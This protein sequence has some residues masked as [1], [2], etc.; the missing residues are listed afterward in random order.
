MNYPELFS[1]SFPIIGCVHLDALPGSPAYG[2]KMNSIIDKAISDADKLIEGGCDGLI[3]E[4]FGD[5]PFYPDR[6]PSITVSAM[7]VL[8]SQIAQ[9][10]ALPIGINVLRNDA[11]A[12]ISIAAA[13]K[14]SFVR[15][16]IHM[17]A[18]LT[19]QG[20]VQGKSFETL[21]LRKSLGSSALIFADINVKHASPL[22][23][24]DIEQCAK[25]LIYRG[26]ADA[27]IVS[28]SGTGS[29][30]SMEELKAVKAISS[31]PVLLGSGVNEDNLINYMPIAD[32]AIIGTAF[33]KDGIV[34]N[35]V[36]QSKVNQFM[37]QLHHSD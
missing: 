9:R 8:A 6:V 36:D 5:A 15:I 24:M 30:A 28:G 3:V 27:L 29:T 2:G 20:I 13:C 10:A 18:M 31:V 32:G 1:S 17:H 11:Q 23:E 21:R 33:K 14:L 7:T 4:N 37:N 22:A 19:D 35:P 12:A 34:T 25:D 26:G 16:N